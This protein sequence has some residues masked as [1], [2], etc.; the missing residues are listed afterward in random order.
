MKKHILSAVMALSLV[1]GLGT[2]A[3]A[4]ESDSIGVIVNSAAIQLDVPVQVFDQVTY[5]SYVPVVMALYPS[6]TAQWVNDRAVVT[7]P[8]LTMEIQPGAK[9]MVANGR[10]LYLPQGVKISGE[11]LMVPSRTL[12]VALGADIAWDG[13][14]SSVVLTAGDGPIASGDAAYQ[15]DVVYWLSH[16]INAESGNQPL[17]G[18]IAVGNVV[19]NRV[20]SSIFPDTVYEVIYQR[21]Q[22]TPVANGSINLTPNE[23]SLIAAKLCLDGA[24]T[25]GSS[26][27]FVNPRSSPNSWASRNRSYV[28]TIGAHAFFA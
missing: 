9:Y 10:Y 14:G 6:A 16:I 5:V 1:F 12:A 3:T 13:A 7:A 18:K 17:E 25:A 26:L 23:E 19:L 28:A 21:N 4:I 11:S 15:S 22:F 27:Y 8:G 24:N 20:A 2:T